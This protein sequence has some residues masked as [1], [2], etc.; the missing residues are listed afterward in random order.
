[1]AL[2]EQAAQR[3][4]ARVRDT[5]GEPDAER[6]WRSVADELDAAVL[7]VSLW[8]L[9]HDG[10]AALAP[11][12]ERSYRRGQAALDAADR[13]RDLGAD[14]IATLS[15][16]ARDHHH[17]LDLLRPIWPRVMKPLVRES[18]T[19]ADLVDRQLALGAARDALLELEDRQLRRDARALVG[20]LD[21]DRAELAARI[22]VLGSR[23]FAD[24][25]GALVA[26]FSI[27]WGAAS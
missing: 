27:W 19:L 5:G 22:T 6:G 20:V 25:P 11:G 26:R 16:R 13:D 14:T 7:A 18:G 15:G 23:I 17:Q 12:L 21:E 8:S 9:R 24:E 3:A 2:A 10:F 1:V 4:A